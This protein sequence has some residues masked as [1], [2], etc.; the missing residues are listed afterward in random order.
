MHHRPAVLGRHDQRLDCGL[1]FSEVLLSLGQL[2]NIVRS[3]LE[4]NELATTG[5]GMGSSKALDQDIA[6]NL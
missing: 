6:V 3:V 5:R 2:L 4:G 1:P